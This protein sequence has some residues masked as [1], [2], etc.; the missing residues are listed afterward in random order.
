MLCICVCMLNSYYIAWLLP[1]S[2]NCLCTEYYI[3]LYHFL[4]RVDHVGGT[5]APAFWRQESVLL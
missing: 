1:V 2:F 3:I 5:E 4:R